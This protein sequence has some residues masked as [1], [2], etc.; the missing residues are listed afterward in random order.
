MVLNIRS[1]RY[2]RDN[3]CREELQNLRQ[4]VLVTMEVLENV[5]ETN[6][7]AIGINDILQNLSTLATI[8]DCKMVNPIL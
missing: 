5:A 2:A 3:E 7:G 4:E 8:N 6:L 1:L